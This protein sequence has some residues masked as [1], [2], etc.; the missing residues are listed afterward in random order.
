MDCPMCRKEV[1]TAQT[2]V[3]HAVRVECPVCLETTCPIVALHC[4]GGHFVCDSCFNL[5]VAPSS[6]VATAAV[7]AAVLPREIVDS[8]PPAVP[9]VAA[10]AA[11]AADVPP[12]EV[13]ISIPHHQ[14]YLQVNPATGRIWQQRGDPT[15]F[16]LEPIGDDGYVLRVDGP[17][18]V[19]CFINSSVS[20]HGAT[21]LALTA[22][23]LEHAAVLRMDLANADANLWEIQGQTPRG[24]KF[25]RGNHY[26]NDVENVTLGTLATRKRKAWEW[27]KLEPPTPEEKRASRALLRQL[28][29][30]DDV[31]AETVPQ[32]SRRRMSHDPQLTRGQGEESGTTATDCVGVHDMRRVP[33]PGNALQQVFQVGRLDAKGYVRMRWIPTPQLTDCERE[34]ARR[35]SMAQDADAPL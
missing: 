20:T 5:M 21:R 3:V 18:D 9:S 29:G 19:P 33:L 10:A 1:R 22:T 17:S 7:V 26:P 16:T 2:Q 15:V 12:R 11:V 4:G 30:G 8:L 25:L 35:F 31:L 6:V 34:L 28:W 13:V 23:A 27:F 32:V 14:T 24:A